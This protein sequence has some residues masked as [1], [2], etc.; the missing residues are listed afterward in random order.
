M[1]FPRPVEPIR[2]PIRAG[3]KRSR[4]GA[5]VRALVAASWWL[6]EQ[7]ER[8]H[9]RRLQLLHRLHDHVE[10]VVVEPGQRVTL[11]LHYLANAAKPGLGLGIAHL[12]SLRSRIAAA[13]SA[14]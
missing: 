12:R 1:R 8:N 13:H 2:S 11:M 5:D 7:R 14:S 9:D 6:L 4:G 10:S 3:S